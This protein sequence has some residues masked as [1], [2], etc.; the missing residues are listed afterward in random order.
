MIM[1]KFVVVGSGISGLSTA[2]HIFKKFPTCSITLLEK[3]SYVGG[4]IKTTK[5][6]DFYCEE[7][8]R[9]IRNSKY[10]FYLG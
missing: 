3:N 1:R 5:V 10:S 9:S 8:P 4:S 2:F 7:G 6:N